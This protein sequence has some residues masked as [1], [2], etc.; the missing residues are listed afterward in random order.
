MP[1]HV[2]KTGQQS[3]FLGG[4]YLYTLLLFFTEH[5]PFGPGR[6]GY[7]QHDHPLGY[8]EDV[9]SSQSLVSNEGFSLAN[10]HPPSF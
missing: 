7:T 5:D 2:Q 1:V 4:K 9:L 6:L 3:E 10:D 8:P